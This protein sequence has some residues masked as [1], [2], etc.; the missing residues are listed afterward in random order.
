MKIKPVKTIG[1]SKLHATLSRPQEVLRVVVEPYLR[2]QAR[3][4]LESA[5]AY[6]GEA[7]S[8]AGEPKYEASKRAW[9]APYAAYPLVTSSKEFARTLTDPGNPYYQTTL[10][11]SGV[12]VGTSHPFAY[13][14]IKTGGVGPYGEAYPARDPWAMT[15]G[16]DQE[17]AQR[18]LDYV[19]SVL[20]ES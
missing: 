12:T 9:D 14:L 15:K 8:F 19:N 20:K 17:L 13:R 18:V 6:G 3:R 1:L 7:W 16:Q 10:T 4:N 5:G 11:D 2:E